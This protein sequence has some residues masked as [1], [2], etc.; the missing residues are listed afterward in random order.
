MIL[1]E[2][3]KRKR[4]ACLRMTHETAVGHAAVIVGGTREQPVACRCPTLDGKTGKP[5][6]LQRRKPVSQHV[7]AIQALPPIHKDPFD[8]LLIA[9][10]TI[11]G[12]TL[13]TADL[14][15]ANYPGPVKLV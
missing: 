7:V 1:T 9:Q 3:E 2:W 12:I 10:A 5:T 8:R 14:H 11:D 6:I 15:L 13:V 4:F